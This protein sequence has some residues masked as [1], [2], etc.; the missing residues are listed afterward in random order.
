MH[1][2]VGPLSKAALALFNWF[3]AALGL[4]IERYP[5]YVRHADEAFSADLFD[6]LCAF[7]NSAFVSGY[8][9]YDLPRLKAWL[10]VCPDLYVVVLDRLLLSTNPLKPRIVGTYKL[11]PLVKSATERA[12]AGTL[13]IIDIP[14]VELASSLDAAAGIWIGD[15]TVVSPLQ[16]ASSGSLGRHLMESIRQ[17]LRRFRG[18]VPIFC[19]SERSDIQA[20]LLR[21]GF[22][23]LHAGEITGKTIWLLPTNSQSTWLR[24]VA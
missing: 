14:A 6:E 12:L 7:L 2:P 20:F 8:K 1:V 9:P 5:Q 17:E 23:P 4:G 16:S 11:A 18:K 21:L 19:R 24:R 13:E 15:L 22:L 10:K 3:K